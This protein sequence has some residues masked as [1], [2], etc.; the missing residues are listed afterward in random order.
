MKMVV[1][2]K[3][4][5]KGYHTRERECNIYNLLQPKVGTYTDIHR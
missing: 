1:E 4:D 2:L 5:I 3:A